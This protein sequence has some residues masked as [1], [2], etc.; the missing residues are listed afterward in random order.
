MSCGKNGL[1][2][3][4]ARKIGWFNASSRGVP[5]RALASWFH[6]VTYSCSSRAINADGMESMMLLR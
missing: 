1:S 5:D 2:G 6:W 4:N 3:S